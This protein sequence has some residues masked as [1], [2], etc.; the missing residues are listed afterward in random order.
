[1]TSGLDSVEWRSVCAISCSLDIVG[2]KWTLLIIRDLL[3]RE[4][5]TFTQFLGS[6]ERISTNILTA[7]LAKLHGYGL[8]ARTPGASKRSFIYTL[9]PKGR[10]LKPV[11]QALGVWSS[12]HLR[13]HQP[14]LIGL[15]AV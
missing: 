1:M 3:I 5:S 7:R 9:T 8:I 10:D 14:G 15:D 2:D 4:Q 6:P 11:I 12:T 13:S